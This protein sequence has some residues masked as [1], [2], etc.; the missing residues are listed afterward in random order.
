MPPCPKHVS[1]CHVAIA[2]LKLLIPLPPPLTGWFV[3]QFLF[4]GVGVEGG[5]LAREQRP[6]E[7]RQGLGNLGIDVSLGR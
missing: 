2:D 1:R 3:L 7:S 5:A 6:Q 4:A